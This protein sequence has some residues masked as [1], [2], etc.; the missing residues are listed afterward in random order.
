MPA[1]ARIY[2]ELGPA[3]LLVILMM[4]AVGIG[5]RGGMLSSHFMNV[6]DIGV[7]AHF[8]HRAV[9]EAELR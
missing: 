4:L 5:M 1:G 3:S 6:D 7:S 9:R 8:V 2:Q